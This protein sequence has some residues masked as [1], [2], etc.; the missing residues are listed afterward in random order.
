[1]DKLKRVNTYFQNLK[2][3]NLLVMLLKYGLGIAS[4]T[5][6][7]AKIFDVLKKGAGMDI[8][9]SASS[10]L[11]I[12][13][14]LC[15]IF[16]NWYTEAVK[17]KILVR[18]LVNIPVYISFKSVLAGLNLGLI[19]PNRLG[20]PFGRALYINNVQKSRLI[21]AALTGSM[22]QLFVTVLV[23]SVAFVFS[24]VWLEDSWNMGILLSKTV[25]LLWGIILGLFLTI[26]LILHSLKAINLSKYKLLKKIISSITFVKEYRFAIQLH[27]IALSIFRYLIFSVQLILLLWLFNVKVPLLQTFMSISFMYLMVAILPRSTLTE[28]GLRGSILLGLMA[29]FTE[30]HLGVLMAA[31]ILWVINVGIPAL[32]GNLFIFRKRG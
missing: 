8:L 19:S 4:Y 27:I 25:M 10:I 1:M 26:P 15:F 21:L 29:P 5:Y 14:V 28:F 24:I 3:K 6:V 20:E 11:I 2:R 17:W 7:I 18:P 23:G 22:A 12:L 30:N 31:S 9:I 16:L 32:V 13:F